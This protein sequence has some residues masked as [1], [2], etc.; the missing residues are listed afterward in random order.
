MHAG[1]RRDESA[2]LLQVDDLMRALERLQTLQSEAK[3][4]AVHARARV[5]SCLLTFYLMERF[6]WHV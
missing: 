4:A 2:C 3:T 6:V 1:N 5:G